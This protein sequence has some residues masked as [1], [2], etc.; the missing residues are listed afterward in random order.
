MYDLH[1]IIS[2]ASWFGKII[3]MIDHLFDHSNNSNIVKYYNNL[4]YL[5]ICYNL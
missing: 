4:I 3:K 5:N 1:C 2:Y